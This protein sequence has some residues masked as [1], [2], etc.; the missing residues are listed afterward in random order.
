[1]T[2]GVGQVCPFGQMVCYG[3]DISKGCRCGERQRAKA[4]DSAASHTRWRRG[5]GVPKKR[6]VNSEVNNSREVCE[7]EG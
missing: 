6:D 4:E 2:V 7:W 1:M 3:G 5:Q